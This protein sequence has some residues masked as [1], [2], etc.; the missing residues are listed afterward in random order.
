MIP[1]ASVHVWS[2]AKDQG[3]GVFGLAGMQG[4]VHVGDGVR[5]SHNYVVYVCCRR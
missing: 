5:A 3:L 4:V 1:T 2:E